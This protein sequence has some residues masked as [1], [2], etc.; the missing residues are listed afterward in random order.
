LRA[1]TERGEGDDLRRRD[2]LLEDGQEVRTT[3]FRT[4]KFG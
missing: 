2:I 1:V 4:A 3:E